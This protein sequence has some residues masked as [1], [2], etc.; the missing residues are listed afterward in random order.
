VHGAGSLGA[1]IDKEAVLGSKY[2]Y[3]KEAAA[4]PKL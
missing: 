4:A 1:T 2:K 3:R